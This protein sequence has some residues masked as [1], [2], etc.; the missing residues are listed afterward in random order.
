MAHTNKQQEGTNENYMK[1]GF[2]QGLI[3]T[4]TIVKKVT[5]QLL[6]Q[7]CSAAPG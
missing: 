6:L 5:S 7:S 4:K 1:A 2:L 3:Q